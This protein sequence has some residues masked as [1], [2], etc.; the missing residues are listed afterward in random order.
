MIS[1]TGGYFT[2]SGSKGGAGLAFSVLLLG[3]V[4]TGLVFSGCQLRGDHALTSPS[5]QEQKQAV[6]DVVPLRTTRQQAVEKLHSAG[7]EGTFG[8]SKSVYYCDLWN[9]QDGQ[10]WHLDVALFFDQ[11]GRLYKLKPAQS[12]TGIAAHREET[13]PPRLQTTAGESLTDR[14]LPQG[15]SAG[16]E[17]SKGRAARRSLIPPTCSDCSTRPN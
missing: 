15:S 10:R 13:I 12:M 7:V 16:D 5:Y 1:E 17:V 3:T 6:L 9:R 14:D 4:V 11:S 2:G 8:I